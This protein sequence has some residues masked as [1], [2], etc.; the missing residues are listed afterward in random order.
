MAQQTIVWTVLPNGRVTQGQYAG[1]LRVSIVVSPRLTPEVASEQVLEA[2]EDWRDWPQTL[3]KLGFALRI[4]GT[5]VEL[6]ATSRADPALWQRLLPLQTPVAGFAF[7]DMS[8]VNLRSFAVRNVLGLVRRY[9]SRLA[10]QSASTHPTLLPWENAHPDLKDML[11]ECGTRTRKVRATEVALPGFERLL[12]ADGKGSVAQQLRSLVFGPQGRYQAGMAGIGA[13]QEGNPVGAGSFRIRALPSDWH[14][15]DGHEPDDD[16]MSLWNTQAEYTLYQANR[17]YQRTQASAAQQALRRPTMADIPKPPIPPEFDFHRIIASYGD[18]PEL[19]K[20]L[21]L[22]VDCVLPPNSVIDQQLAAAGQTQGV[23]SLILRWDERRKQDQDACPGTV[24]Q[25]DHLRFSV[26]NR[27]DDHERGML[28]LRYANDNW[29]SKKNQSLFDVYQVDPDAT[30]LKTVDFLLSAQRLVAKSL[31][32]GGQ[33]AVTYTTGDKQAV[34]ALRSGGLGVSRHGRAAAVAQNAAA[35]A[36]KDQAMKAGPLAARKIAL[37]AED[38]LR[39]YRIDVQ[40]LTADGQGTWRSLCQRRGIYRLAGTDAVIDLPD[41]EGYVKGASTS[42][43]AGGPADGVDPDDHYLHESLFRWTG[44]SLVAAR[45]G[46]T[47]RARE[48]AG[49]GV[50]GEAPEEVN[51]AVTVGGNGLAVDFRALKAS[52]PRLRFGAAYRFRARLVDLAGNSLAFDDPSLKEDDNQTDPVTYWRFEPVDPPALLQRA[53]NSEGES[54]ERLVIRSNWNASAGDYL[55]TPAFSVAIASPASADF[56]YGPVNERHIVPPKSSQLQCETHGLFDALFASTADIKTAYEIACRDA[57][58]LY[59]A[60]PGSQVELVTPVSLEHVATTDDLPLR[61][62]SADNP[63]GDRFAPGQYVIRRE[64]LVNTPYLPDGAAGGVALRAAAG[65]R[66]PGVDKPIVLGPNAVVVRAPNEELV[67]L[68]SYG[69][70]WPDTQGLCLVL[71]ER[72][73]KFSD[74][75]C[76]ASSDDAGLP[77]WDDEQRVLTLFVPKGQ[78]VRL[79]YSSFVHKAFLPTFGLPDWADSEGERAYIREMAQLGCHWMITPY[80]P[81]VL[82][83]ATQQPVCNPEFFGLT[84]QREA[85]DQH[86]VLGARVRLHGPST[87]KIEVEAEWDEW[88]DDLDNP[89]GPQLQTSRGM[90]GEVLL[91]ENFPN[92][93]TL[94]AA[95]DQQ[96]PP[97]SGDKRARGDRHEFGDTKF[98]LVRYQLRATTRFREYLP[99]ALYEQR[100]NV[101][102]LG[103][104]AEGRLMEVGAS[105]DP[106]APVL[107]KETGTALNS[108]VLASAPPDEPRLQ[109]ILPTFLWKETATGQG[110][111]STRYGNGLRVW[112]D[113][114]WFSSGNGEL[115]GVVILGEGRRFTDIPGT[116]VP[117][118]TQWGLDPL[119]DTALPKHQASA[120]DF[121]ACVA[122]EDNVPLQEAPGLTAGI[123]GHRVYWDAQRAQWYCDIELDPGR[124]YMPFV[125]LAL[126]RYQ[127][128]AIHSAKIS[129]V[130]LADFAQVLPR[131]RAT[132]QRNGAELSLTLR[133]SVPDHGPMKFSVDSEYLGISFVP[134]LGQ[135]GETGRNK[136]ELVLQTRDPDIDSDLAW[137]DAALLASSL[138]GVGESTGSTGGTIVKKGIAVR[139]PVFG[140]PDFRLPVLDIPDL[141]QLLDPP[142]WTVKAKLPGTIDRPARVAIREYERYYTDR[143]VPEVRSGTTLQRRIVEERL[144]YCAFFDLIDG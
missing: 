43:A 71:A 75:P 94:D 41:D 29:G 66:L 48:D 2:F 137:S 40:E 68:V 57:G 102:R 110:M 6:S 46:R 76:E 112:L 115:L 31:A 135:A 96:A 19:L 11:A 58:T 106:G 49:S 21:G 34:A 32:P 51:D 143:S 125:R 55:Q 132:F 111:D 8:A 13:D 53:R 139:P 120:A 78:I 144:V 24:W 56:E 69:K 33:G 82:V 22:I 122:R 121:S 62:P 63:T 80:R 35:A 119:W 79:R 7:K 73:G 127:P 90:L 99:P 15:P 91:A 114:P 77:A 37:F 84:V 59:D 67:L 25:A 128:N 134:G 14:A 36:L 88:V 9:Y 50:Q 108:V 1:Q 45:P 101:T 92:V 126:V 89:A 44:W 23:M 131:R 118:V 64:A 141:G 86:A 133:G 5:V 138:T 124:S 103:P 38:V 87:G 12:D 16:L 95:I 70:N 116:L 117:L 61:L 123:V 20:K 105:D 74:P 85:G 83:H 142:I 98:R 93:F 30:A 27:S 136:I 104:V 28:N 72:T 97:V 54:L 3:A 65:Y 100:D 140:A 42:S 17:F 10:V 109:Y 130:V 60:G 18:Y 4:G 81:L 26:H 113:R 47:L 107:A 52:L 39:G 129:R